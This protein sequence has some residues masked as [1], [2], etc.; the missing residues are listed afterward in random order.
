MDRYVITISRRFASNGHA[1][2]GRVSEILGI[3]VYDRSSVEAR[4]AMLQPE[5]EEVSDDLDLQGT[6][7][8][9]VK[10]DAGRGLLRGLFRREVREDIPDE[11]QME[12]DRQCDAIRSLAAEG[13]CIIIGRCADEIF[14]KDPAALHVFIFAT[15]EVRLKNSME[16]LHT[17]EEEALALIQNEDRSREKYRKRFAGNAEDELAGRHLLL[18]SGKLGVQE[19]AK[20]I[21]E[22]AGYLFGDT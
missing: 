10:S 9:A 15:D 21:A 7:E 14:L 18:D 8:S 13:S 4:V 2:A 5:T 16:M 1:I 6:G 17:G 22:A 12:F 20:I 11:A 19:C 3:P